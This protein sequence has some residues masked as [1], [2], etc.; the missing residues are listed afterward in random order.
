MQRPREEDDRAADG[1]GYSSRKEPTMSVATRLVLAA[2]CGFSAL[3]V[4]A[5][6]DDLKDLRVFGDA[7]H[8]NGRWR[9]EIL[10]MQRDGKDTQAAARINGISICMDNLAQMAQENRKAAE[11]CTTKVVQNLPSV[12]QVEAKCPDASFRSTITREGAGSFLV[13]GEGTRGAG[14][15]YAMKVRYSYQGACRSG[16]GAVNL[17]K[18]SEQCQRA[19]AQMAKLSPDKACGSL[20]G[21]QRRMCENQIQQSLSRVNAMCAQ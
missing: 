12:A 6:G 1:A 8:Q 11:K 13:E 21:D 20:S 15:R 3:P 7:A 17:N 10:K 18:E 9:M 16:E 5:A 14:E 19:R 2:V 4:R